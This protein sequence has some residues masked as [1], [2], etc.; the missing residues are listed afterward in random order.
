MKSISIQKKKTIISSVLVVLV[1]VCA[2]E[3]IPRNAQWKND[4]TLFIHDVFIS[5]NSCLLNNN[6]GWC[7]LN[8]YESNAGKP[9]LS[10]PYL[11]SAK[12]YLFKATE[13]K[14]EYVAAYLNLTY[15]YYHLGNPDSAN[16]FIN[17]VRTLYPGHPSIKNISGLIAQQYLDIFRIL[18]AQQKKLE[19]IQK[20]RNGLTLEI[21]DSLKAVLWYNIGGAY[22]TINMFDSARKAWNTTLQLNP[23]YTDAL[24]GLNAI[25]SIN[26]N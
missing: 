12:K 24:R 25:N 16:Y 19:A 11:D 26:H 2:S 22:S 20:L 9:Q 13:L 3:T 5:P 15:V 21:S 4:N 14:K 7:Y 1:I 6:V 18:G 8:F 23:A 10:L 17:F